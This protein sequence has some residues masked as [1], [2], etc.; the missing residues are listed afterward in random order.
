MLEELARPTFAQLKLPKRCKLVT[1]ERLTRE[2]ERLGPM[3]CYVRPE[4]VD[5]IA[6]G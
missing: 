5:S 4:F 2:V 3:A 6:E 1:F